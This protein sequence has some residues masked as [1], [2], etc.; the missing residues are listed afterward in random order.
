VEEPGALVNVKKIVWSREV[1]ESEDERLNRL[2]AGSEIIYFSTI[3]RVERRT[4]QRH[5]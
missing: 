4:A 5:S 1:A 2:K 3:A